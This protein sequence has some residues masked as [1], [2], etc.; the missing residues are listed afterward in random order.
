[1]KNNSLFVLLCFLIFTIGATSCKIKQ[2][3]I[4]K[5]MIVV[6]EDSTAAA[7]LINADDEDHFFTKITVIDMAIQ[8]HMSP[9]YGSRLEMIKLYRDFLNGQVL[10]PSA[11]DRVWID[12]AFHHVKDGINKLNGNLFPPQISIVKIKPDHYGEGTFYTRGSTIFIP[13]H[14]FDEDFN[15]HITVMYHEFWHVISRN[16]PELKRK[17]YEL[18]G[19]LPHNKK[20]IYSD[21][22]GQFLLTNPDGVVD[23]YAINLNGE[24]TIPLILSKY[25]AYSDENKVF[26]N[27]LSFDFFSIDATGRVSNQPAKLGSMEGLFAKIKDNTQYIIHPDEIMADNFQLAVMAYQTGD[28]S[29]FSPGGKQ[30]IDQ[31]TALLKTIT[32]IK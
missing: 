19:F 17:A 5:E 20:L 31:L 11:K 14:V 7:N 26:F 30:L 28:Y 25:D 27:Y 24:T 3:S 32:D 9:P 8:M 1:M 4:A 12:S 18:I 23:N 10:Q 22:I 21:S 6:L 2:P 16:N 13:D 29:A 15:N